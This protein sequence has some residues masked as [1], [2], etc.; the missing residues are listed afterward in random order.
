LGELVRKR[1]RERAVRPAAREF[2]KVLRRPVEETNG[3]CRM[4]YSS[5]WV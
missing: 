4:F 1:L 3:D 2:R 5:F